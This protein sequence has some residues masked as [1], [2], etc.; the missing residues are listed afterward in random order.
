MGDAGIGPVNFSCQGQSSACWCCASVLAGGCSRECQP[1]HSQGRLVGPRVASEP[2]V[3]RL[4]SNGA[5]PT[6]SKWHGAAACGALDRRWCRPRGTTSAADV[7]MPAGTAVSSATPR[8]LRGLPHLGHA[9]RAGDDRPC[10]AQVW[11]WNITRLRG[12]DKG[13][14]CQLYVM[15]DS[16]SQVQPDLHHLPGRRLPPGHGLHR[17]GDRPQR[18]HPAHRARRPR[19]LDVLQTRLRASRRPRRD[20][21]PLPTPGVE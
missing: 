14:F 21:V 4:C 8:R 16:Y 10:G 20:P 18:H 5:H 15:I 1:S 17:R 9:P 2:H 3:Y 19:H 7:S 6:Y 12:P 11:T 13:I